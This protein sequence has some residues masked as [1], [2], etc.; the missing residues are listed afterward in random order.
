M[1]SKT[2]PILVGLLLLC[3]P[4]AAEGEAAIADAGPSG[5]TILDSITVTATRGEHSLAE[6]PGTVT[7][8]ESERIE[9]LMMLDTRDLVRYEPG[10]YV[11]NSA[12]RLGLG[13][14]NIRGVGGNRVLTRIDGVPAAESFD[15]GPFDVLPFTLDLDSVDRVEILRGPGSSLYGSDALGGVVSFETKNPLDLLTA[16]RTAYLG[17][18]T[19]WDGRQGATSTALTTAGGGERWQTM[20][21]ITYAAGGE[22]DNRGSIATGD[23]TR[24]L[25]NPQDHQGIG[26]LGKLVHQRSD[27]NQYELALETFNRE[28]DTEALSDLGRINLGAI[29]GFG[30]EITYLV[31]KRSSLAHDQQRRRRLSLENSRTGGAIDHLLWRA[32]AQTSTTEQRTVELRSTTRGGGFFGPLTTTEVE[33]LGLMTFE[34]ET[35]GLEVQL[36]H[37]LELRR[38][39]LVTLGATVSVDRFDQLRDRR[40][41]D[42]LSGAE[43]ATSDGL[44]YPTKYFPPSRVVETGLFAQTELEFANGRLTLIPGLRYDR[45]ELG[46][47]P[48]DPI[49]LSGN[50]GTLPPVEL[51]DEAFSPKLGLIAALSERTSLHMQYAHGFRAP[52]YSAVNSGFTHLASGLTR[53]PNPDLQPEESDGFEL[54][55]RRA[56]TRGSFS[57]TAFD[58]RYDGFIELVTLG[59]NPTTGLVEFQQRNIAEARIRGLEAAA[60]ARFGDRW[61]LRTSLAW[62]EGEDRT[63]DVPLNSIHPPQV[64]A[65][66]RRASAN[67]RWSTELAGRFVAAKGRADLDPGTRPQFATPAYEVFDLYASWEMSSRLTLNAGI[68]NL[69]NSSYWE[70]TDALGQTEGS[71][72]I[73][74][75][76]APGRNVSIT[77]RYRK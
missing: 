76:T 51:D 46:V 57:V 60:D 18:T 42:A 71:S 77:L 20:A 41:S 25:P 14:F 31:D 30:P 61:Y 12:T 4:A 63:R 64:A 49:F 39:Q 3:G 34:Q 35:L 15:F 32:H 68:W 54:G 66:L 22:R 45:I 19:G 17:L 28:N 27:R 74:R 48:D 29:F 36:Q 2:R 70:W 69:T 40:E 9:Q 7:V 59:L 16:G 53:I 11:E 67:Q 73:D 72:T 6:V 62:I 44:I 8:V 50:E 47:D 43:L 23:S 52:P 13:G 38:P 75:F 24:T 65:G 10:V 56:G 5:G 55:L 21:S 37:E 33:R 58:N 1:H 26:F